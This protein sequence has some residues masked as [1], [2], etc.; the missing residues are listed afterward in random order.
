MQFF[1]LYCDAE[2]RD[3][4]P[5]CNDTLELC[6]SYL[7]ESRSNPNISYTIFNDN[8][9]GERIETL[10][11]ITTITQFHNGEKHGYFF[12]YRGDELISEGYYQHGLKHGVFKEYK[13]VE[14][15]K[16]YVNDKLEGE[17]SEYDTKNKCLILTTVLRG[18]EEGLKAIYIDA[19]IRELVDMHMGLEHGVHIGFHDNGQVKFIANRAYG[20]LHG[21]YLEFEE[22][23][24]LR[25][26]YN[27]I[28]D[29]FE[30]PTYVWENDSVTVRYFSNGKNN[31]ESI[32]IKNNRLHM[33]RTYE[34][35]MLHGPAYIWYT[36]GNL[37][38]YRE[39]AYNEKHGNSFRWEKTGKII[40]IHEY[41]MGEVIFAYGPPEPSEPKP[42]HNSDY[43]SEL[44]DGSDLDS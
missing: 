1:K 40:S 11:D 12:S 30:G 20:K 15:V 4:I 16:R 28:H 24:K 44:S 42:K 33:I 23:G 5:L 32:I 29:K 9:E 34:N 19:K 21:K 2:S 41:D 13:D 27:Y 35:C 17:V 8:L 3:R 10:H 14:C 31:G 18:I 38:A 43:E 22:D 39:Y 25:L 37:A 26:K 7:L 36:N 6:L